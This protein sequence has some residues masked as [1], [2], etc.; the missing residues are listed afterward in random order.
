LNSNPEELQVDENKPKKHQK[1]NLSNEG[2]EEAKKTLSRKKQNK[3]DHGLVAFLTTYH[4]T[5]WTANCNCAF[6][7]EEDDDDIEIGEHINYNF[8]YKLVVDF[9]K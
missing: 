3:R 1:K 9:A 6:V 5:M 8:N 4:K 2:D 7:Y